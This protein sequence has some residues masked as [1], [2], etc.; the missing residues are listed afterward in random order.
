MRSISLLVAGGL[1]SVPAIAAKPQIQWDPEFDFS[2]VQTFAWQDTAGESLAQSQP[3]LHEHIINAIEFELTNSG[4]RE[5]TSNPD[6]LVTYYGSTETNYRL[7]SDSYGYGFGGYGMGGWG[8]YGYGMGGPVST[9]TRVVEYDRG[10]L[11][12]DIVDADAGE[13]VWR[14]SVSDITVSDSLEKMQ[15]YVT[16]AIVKMAKQAR[17]LRAKAAS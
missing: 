13:L 15:K 7:Q 12:V 10:T 3:F 2:Q 11:V 8:Y 9:T 1:L 4:F 6:V 17:K 14:G 5:T 16:K